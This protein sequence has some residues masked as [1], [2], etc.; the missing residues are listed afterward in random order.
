VQF[1]SR[2]S[3]TNEIDDN[4]TMKKSSRCFTSVGALTNDVQ[5]ET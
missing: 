2:T 4:A 5:E 1:P 3:L